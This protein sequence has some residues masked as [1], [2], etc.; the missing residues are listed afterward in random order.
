[1]R[2]TSRV[3][4]LSA[5]VLAGASVHSDAGAYTLRDSLRGATMGHAIGGSFD[6][7]GWTVT[8]RTDRIWYAIPRLVTGSI[9]FTVDHIALSTLILDDH[10]IFTMYEDGYGIGEP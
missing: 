4:S 5:F 9:E 8:G 1:M 3:L 6:A 7:S 10:E 2:P